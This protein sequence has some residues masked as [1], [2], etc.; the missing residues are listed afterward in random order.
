MLN[1]TR[2]TTTTHLEAHH[3]EGWRAGEKLTV[4][5]LI[6]LCHWHHNKITQREAAEAR[7]K[8]PPPQKRRATQHPGLN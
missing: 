3:I 5:K 4:D 7:R 8:N 6:T 1:G 2:C